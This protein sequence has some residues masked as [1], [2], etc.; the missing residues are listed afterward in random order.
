MIFQYPMAALNPVTNIGRKVT[1]SI[2]AHRTI[3]QSAALKQASSRLAEMGLKDVGGLLKSFPHQLSGGQRQRVMIAMALSLS[4]RLFFF[5]SRRRH[6]SWN[7]DWS[8]DV[9]SSD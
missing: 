9:C 8:S 1:K 5:S 2:R 7:C 6:T 3:S 4:P